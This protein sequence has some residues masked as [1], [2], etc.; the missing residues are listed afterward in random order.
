MRIHLIIVRQNKDG[1]SCMGTISEI[2]TKEDLVSHLVSLRAAAVYD[3]FAQ[4]CLQKFANQCREGT[5]DVHSLVTELP[6]GQLSFGSFIEQLDNLSVHAAVETKRNANRA[7]TRN[8]LKETFRIAQAYCESSSQ[9]TLL[10]SQSWY[11][12]A[13]IVVNCLSHSFRLEYRPYDL[14]KLP[15]TYDRVTLDSSMNGQSVSMDIR[16]LLQLSDDILA[17]ARFELER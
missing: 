12:F 11:Q 6:E 13:R 8:F 17:F 9:N 10:T 5:A 15:V 16:V 7:T 2:A 1:H 14:T 3:I 4:V